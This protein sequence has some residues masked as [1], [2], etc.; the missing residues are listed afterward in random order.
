MTVTDIC[1]TANLDSLSERLTQAVN[2]VTIA[3]EAMAEHKRNM[4]IGTVLPV[5]QLLAEA[6]ALLTTIL[7]LHRSVPAARSTEVA[8]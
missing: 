8:S 7:L 3:R 2:L 6:T 1:I 5:E 4:A